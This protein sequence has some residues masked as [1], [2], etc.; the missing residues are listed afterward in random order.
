MEEKRFEQEPAEET[1][2]V[3]RGRSKKGAV[4]LIA[5]VLCLLVVVCAL[6]AVD[7]D[8]I[9]DKMFEDTGKV[10]YYQPVYGE[11]V[12]ENEEYLAH[13]YAAMK[14][15]V[16][17][18]GFFTAEYPFGD[19]DSAQEAFEKA[20]EH[21]NG[22]SVLAKYFYSL[23]CGCDTPAQ[24]TRFKELF[25]KEFLI[26]RGRSQLPGGFTCQKIYDLQ[27][28][29]QGEEASYDG[30]ATCQVWMVSYRIVRNDGTV[31]NYSSGLDNGQARFFV[32]ETAEGFRIKEIIG[33]YRVN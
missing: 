7:F 12:W 28:V 6:A 11:N 26:K 16:C 33:I 4:I 8:A 22:A 32:E 5:V 18:D 25:C 20:G 29:Y 31:L 13:A 10:E 23:L 24:K 15:G 30:T 27:F 21:Q 1:G 14:I 17:E 9:K 19:A 2:A 3:K